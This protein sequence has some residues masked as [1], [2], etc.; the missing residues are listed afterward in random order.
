MTD[1]ATVG[2]DALSGSRQSLLRDDTC[3]TDAEKVVFKG[4]MKYF[5]VSFLQLLQIFRF[6]SIFFLVFLL[7]FFYLSRYVIV[8]CKNIY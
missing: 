3:L 8:A 7:F 6:L 2:L 1:S 4:L 5:V